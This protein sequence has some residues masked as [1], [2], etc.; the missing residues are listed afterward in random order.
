MDDVIVQQF[1]SF[2]VPSWGMGVWTAMWD[3]RYFRENLF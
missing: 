1:S 3:Y 2:V